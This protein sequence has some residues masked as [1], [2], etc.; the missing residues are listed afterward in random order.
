MFLLLGASKVVLLGVTLTLSF[1]CEKAYRCVRTQAFGGAE[2]VQK[3]LGGTEASALLANV[4]SSAA[5]P[6]P[7]VQVSDDMQNALAA[8]ASQLSQ[9]THTHPSAQ[10]LSVVVPSGG[11]N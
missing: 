6:A 11:A 4:A 9:G 7:P 3:L 5:P 10:P 2:Q 1:V 8:L